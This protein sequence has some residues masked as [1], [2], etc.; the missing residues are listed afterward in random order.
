MKKKSASMILQSYLLLI[1]AIVVAIV[2]GLVENAFFK[3]TNLVEDRK[4]VV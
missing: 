3:P 2:F 1:A 4:S